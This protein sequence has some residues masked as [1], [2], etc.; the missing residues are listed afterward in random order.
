[1]LVHFRFARKKWQTNWVYFVSAPS[2]SNGTIKEEELSTSPDYF[3]KCP[4]CQK[5]CQSFQALKEHMEIAHTDLTATSENSLS[6]ASAVSPTPLGGTTGSRYT[7]AQC[8]TNFSSKEQLEKH[9]LLH[10]PNAQVVSKKSMLNQRNIL[11]IM[12]LLSQNSYHSNY[13]DSLRCRYLLTTYLRT[14]HITV[15]TIGSYL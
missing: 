1:M 14:S 5:C 9:E 2:L 3:I 11:C 15:T 6:I 10:S 12:W 8:S 4:Q 7:C 13:N